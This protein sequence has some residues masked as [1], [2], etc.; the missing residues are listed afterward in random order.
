MA[1]ATNRDVNLNIRATDSTG[2]GVK[3]ATTALQRFAAAQKATQAR[4]DLYANTEKSARDLAAQANAAADATATLGKR[5]ADAKRPSAQLK[6]DFAETRAEAKR[7][8]DEFLAV[9]TA[10]GR[11]NGRVSPQ[12]GSFAAFERT[13]EALRDQ[14]IATDGADD[15]INRLARDLPKA[16]AAQRRMAAGTDAAAASTRKQ[17]A[18]GG[19]SGDI[20]DAYASKG[21]RGPLGL[22]PYEL[23]NL[24]Y[25]VN[26]LFTQIAGG[27]PVMQAFAQQGGQIAQIFPAAMGAILRAIPVIGLVTLAFAPFVT[28]LDEVNDK[29]E[30][31]EQFDLLLTRSGEGASYSAKGLAD[32]ATKLDA[33]DGSLKDARDSLTQFVDASVDPAY[34]ERFG[35]AALDTSKVLKVDVKDAAELVTKAFTG[36]ADAILSLDDQLNFLTAS[37]RK[38]IERL[39]ESKKDAEARTY[40]FDIFSRKYGETAE[41][42]RGP[43]DTILKNFGSSWKAFSNTVNFI[44]FSKAKGEINDLIRLVEKLS[45]LLP[46]VDKT[47]RDSLTRQHAAIDAEIKENEGRVARGMGD[48]P[49]NGMPGSSDAYS[50]I[51]RLEDRRNEVNRAIAEIDKRNTP[52][53]TP[54]D[55]TLRPPTNANTTKDTQSDAEK[56]AERLAKAQKEFNEDLDA[57]NLKRRSELELLGET[58]KQQEI[59][60]AVEAARA[61]AADGKLVFTDAQAQSIRDSVGALYD[62]TAQQEAFNKVSEVALELATKRGEVETREAFIS[63]SLVDEKLTKEMALYDIR[64][65]QLGQLYD[66]EQKARD[67]EASEKSVNDLLAKQGE[68]QTQLTFAQEQGDQS[69]ATVLS[70]ELEAV[71]AQLLQAIDNSIAFW[72]SIGGPE[73]AAAI[74]ALEGAR[75]RVVETGKAV[76]VTGKDINTMIAQGGANAFDQFAQKVADGENV[77]KAFGSSFLQM[78]ADFLKQIAAMI[79]QQAILNAIGGGTGGGNG[80]VGG[81]I[82]SAVVGLFRHSGGLVGSGG[83]L[84]RIN[85]A[86]MIGAVP[87]HT[88]G[89][90]GQKPDE[91]SAMLRIGEEVLTEDDPRHRNNLG[92]GGSGSSMK[93]VNVFD[94]NDLLTKMVGNDD[95]AQIFLNFV[96]ANGSA[97]KAA[98]G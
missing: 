80:G 52:V 73:A 47:S 36:N 41:K 11:L 59:I 75:E 15:A 78:A 64:A 56:A 7:L 27:T 13:A 25:Q 69:A 45:F 33:Y 46:G 24:G 77:I 29:A 95:G 20:V 86:A 84:R 54:T 97:F 3:S 63:R 85:P 23:Q 2:P 44:D 48:I 31:L 19:V 4:R 22:R 38:H 60:N 26:D 68:L 72:R 67:R 70:S 74:L 53:V 40:A 66:L 37:E 88:G 92:K 9:A 76:V 51:A 42:M 49:R 87:Y 57:A 34:L 83:G 96:R 8:K 39:K 82:A 30:S 65:D 55:T 93:V 18:G 50:N 16:E 79:I 62:A 6:A 71:N 81:G 91:V 12:A 32:L 58:A 10:G 28:A 61:K 35:K 90:A 14:R 89:I 43:W 21:G 17:A 5:L 1:N 94:P 98:I